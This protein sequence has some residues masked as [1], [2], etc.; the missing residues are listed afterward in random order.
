[1]GHHT[2]GNLLH[3]EKPSGRQV[4]SKLDFS[5]LEVKIQCP[6]MTHP[7]TGLTCRL[8]CSHRNGWVLVAAYAPVKG[9]PMDARLELRGG[10]SYRRHDR[11]EGPPQDRES[12]A[13]HNVLKGNLSTS[14]ALP[15]SVTGQTLDA[16]FS[17]A[18]V[19]SL[20]RLGKH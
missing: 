14:P 16:C 10:E 11:A 19:Y 18:S 3:L 8:A 9:A 4:A 6:A 17:H 7:I 5:A 20:G 12:S 15:Q 1:M 2:G 13:P